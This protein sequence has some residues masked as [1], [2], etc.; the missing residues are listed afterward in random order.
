MSKYFFKKQLTHYKVSER[1]TQEMMSL[2]IT[3]L[4]D[5]VKEPRLNYRDM[6]FKIA[7]FLLCLYISYHVAG[8]PSEYLR[9][10]E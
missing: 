5:K 9:T 6:T 3:F 2:T 10:Q 1:M 4:G 8:V 7:Y